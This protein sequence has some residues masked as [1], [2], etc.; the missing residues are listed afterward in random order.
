MKRQ[1]VEQRRRPDRADDQVL[2]PGLE[3]VL[4]AHL[5]RAQHVERDR[6]QLEAEE[7]RRPGSARRDEHDHAERS[8]EQQRVELAVRRLAPARRRA[9]TAAPRPT[10]AAQNS[11]VSASVEVVDRQRAA[12]RR[13]TFVAPLPDRQAGG[14]AER[15]ERQHRHEPGAHERARAAARPAARRRRRRA[16]RPAARA[17]PSRCPGPWPA[18]RSRR[19]LRAGS[20]SAAGA[21]LT[22]AHRR[23]H[24]AGSP[25]SSAACG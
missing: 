20:G 6:Q 18:S 13:S 12:R 5:G 15:H 3:R 8:S 7:Q 2:Q 25:A 14:D 19:H 21:P 1:P 16:A 9:T 22:W 17:P 11:S 24:G 23:L 4:A 10:P